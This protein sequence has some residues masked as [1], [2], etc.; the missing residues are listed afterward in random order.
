MGKSFSEMRPE[1]AS[2]F[3]EHNL[4][5]KLSEQSESQPP[6]PSESPKETEQTKPTELPAPTEPPVETQSKTEYDYEF[7][8]QAIR[9]DCIAIG[10]SMGYTPNTSLPLQKSYGGIRHLHRNPI[11]AAH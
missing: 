10:Q 4:P 11:R 1:L 6:T 7:D 5:L 3:S 8:I 2:E 9:A